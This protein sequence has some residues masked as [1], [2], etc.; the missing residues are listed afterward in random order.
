MLVLYDGSPLSESRPTRSLLKGI[1]VIRYLPNDCETGGIGHDKSLLTAYFGVM[2]DKFQLL[3]ELY[4]YVKPDDGIYTITAEALRVN[5]INLIEHENQAITYKEAG[6]KLYAFL[7][8]HSANGQYKL[9]P[10]GHGV[11]F[12]VEFYCEKLI[13]RNS[14]KHHCSYR[15]RDTSVLGNALID[16]GRVPSSVSGSLGSWAQYFGVN[17]GTLHDAKTDAL[18]SARV[19]QRQLELIR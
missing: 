14:W 13:S 18:T 1:V 16:A 8:R 4:L 10:L 15:L 7:S 5:G 3:D 11:T 9:L 12:D 17:M 6:Q 2:D 19:Y